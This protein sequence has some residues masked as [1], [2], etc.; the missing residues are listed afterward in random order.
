MSYTEYASLNTGTLRDQGNTITQGV[1]TV[2]PTNNRFTCNNTIT[3][4]NIEQ[5]IKTYKK[6]YDIYT[7]KPETDCVKAYSGNFTVNQ[8]CIGT[9]TCPYEADAQTKNAFYIGTTCTTNTSNNKILSV[10]D[11]DVYL[12]DCGA[13]IRDYNNNNSSTPAYASAKELAKKLDVSYNALW[14]KRSDL[15]NKMNELL[16]NNPNSILYENQNQLDAGVYTTILWT[17]LVTSSLYYIFTK[18]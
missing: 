2:N 13:N 8:D 11:L 4:T 7:T 6:L 12:D 16:G 3:S 15:D 18:I 10:K 17:V 1:S 14:Q 9:G 5:A